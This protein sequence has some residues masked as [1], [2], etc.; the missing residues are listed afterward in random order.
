MRLFA[1]CAIMASSVTGAC[2]TLDDSV[3]SVSDPM[4]VARGKDAFQRCTGC[5]AAA[6][7]ARSQAGP[8]LYGTVGRVAGSH[9]GFPYTDA[10]AAS[11]IVWDAETLDAY[12]ADPTGTVPGSEM[13]RGTVRDADQRAAI[14]AYLISLNH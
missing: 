7:G 12:L 1:V 8:N 13:Q 14:V 9:P 11:K 6:P 10:L 4:M 2:A 3:V 5:H